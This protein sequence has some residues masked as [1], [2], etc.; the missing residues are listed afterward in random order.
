M[1]ILC[2]Y[3]QTLAVGIPESPFCCPH[4]FL[5]TPHHH[6]RQLGNSKT[7][8]LFLFGCG[9]YNE[10]MQKINN[11]Y[12]TIKVINADLM[13]SDDVTETFRESIR[14]PVREVNQ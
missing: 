10:I 9:V 3:P 12:P 8:F 14:T 2:S 4:F 5:L 6:L 11:L 1:G 7:I 13:T